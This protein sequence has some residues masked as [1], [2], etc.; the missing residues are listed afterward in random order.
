[1]YSL[2]GL[3]RER[4]TLVDQKTVIMNRL[5]AEQA[6]QSPDRRTLKRLRQ[7]RRLLEKQIK[8]VDVNHHQ[9]VHH[10]HH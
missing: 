2:K 1:M 10:H 3:S 9:K 4:N 6:C 7:Q 5:H 8:E